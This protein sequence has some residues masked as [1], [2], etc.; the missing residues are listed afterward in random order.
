VEQIRERDIERIKEREEQE[1]EAQA[2]VQRMKDMEREDKLKM[3][4]LIV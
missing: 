1:K 4:V 3:E 2:L